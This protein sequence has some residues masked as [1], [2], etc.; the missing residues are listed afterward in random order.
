MPCD[1][2]LA[3]LLPTSVSAAERFDEPDETAGWPVE[4][5]AIAHAVA[6]RRRDYLGVRDCARSALSGLGLAPVAIGSGPTREPTWPPGV[7]GSLTHCAGYRAAAVASA[8]QVRAIG[9]DAEPHAELPPGVLDVVGLPGER[10]ALAAL[11]GPWHWDRVLF[12]AKESVYKAW[13][14]LTGQW[15]GFE[16]ASIELHPELGRFSARLLRAAT[17]ADG[18]SLTGFEGRWLVAG[19]LI[20]TAV[21]LPRPPDRASGPQGSRGGRTTALPWCGARPERPADQ[22]DGEGA[23]RVP[24]TRRGWHDD[25]RCAVCRR[26][27]SQ[28]WL[29]VPGGAVG[30]AVGV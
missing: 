5:A 16:E 13:F 14:P 17:L 12:C 24:Y 29:P 3:R 2:L 25:A 22:R 7:V 6:A 20:L 23:R 30:T 19:G 1:P 27:D 8:D 26:A 9:I 28:A 21:V 10:A 11:P 15:L 4:R 18:T